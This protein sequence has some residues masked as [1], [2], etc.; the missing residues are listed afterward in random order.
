MITPEMVDYAAIRV[1]IR[2]ALV[3]L[4]RHKQAD[5]FYVERDHPWTF[6]FRRK[7]WKASNELQA[8][9]KLLRGLENKNA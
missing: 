4:R 8:V 6:M 9:I 7:Y 1:A 5:I 2:S 3:E